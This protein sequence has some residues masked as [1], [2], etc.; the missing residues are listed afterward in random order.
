MNLSRRNLMAK[1]ATIIGATQCVKAGSANSNS[2]TNPS[3][4]LI[5][6]TWSFGEAANNEALK[7][8]KKGG[9][10]M[11]SIEKGI[12]IT[13]NDPNNSSVGIGGLPNSDGV[14]QLDACITV[15]YTHL[16]LPTKRIV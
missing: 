6:S 5:I 12:N 9:S 16:T 8:N 15:S 13:E 1:G 10:L 7:V 2:K 4:P 11:D 14:V 3:M